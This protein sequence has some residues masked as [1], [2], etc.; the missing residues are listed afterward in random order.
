MIAPPWRHLGRSST[1]CPTALFL[2]PRNLWNLS[3]QSASVAIMATGM[4]L[5]IV[6]RNID[7]SVG[8]MLGFIGMVMAMIQAEW[9]PRPSGSASTSRTPGSSRSPSGIVVGRRDRRLPGLHHR[10]HRRAVVHRHARR[11]ARLA[12]R[13]RSGSRRARRSRRSTAP[14]S[15]SAAGPRG[16]SAATLSWIVGHRACVGIVYSLVRRAAG[17]GAYGFPLRPIWADVVLGVLGCRR[18]SAPSGSPTA[19]RGRDLRRSSTPQEHGIPI[20][21]GGLIIPTGHREPGPDRDR[22]RPSS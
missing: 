19:T 7:L 20:P 8:S 22:R 6:S 4:V 21:A 12:R 17:D 16:R 5:I 15:S 10:L 1:S 2:T 14:S 13:S 18:A 3:V 9:L 11:P